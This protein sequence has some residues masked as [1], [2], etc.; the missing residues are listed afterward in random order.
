LDG[1]YWSFFFG[2]S[3]LKTRESEP[4]MGGGNRI[5]LA[6]KPDYLR[7][8]HACI[9]VSTK[10]ECKMVAGPIVMPMVWGAPPTKGTG[11]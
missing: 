8:L 4:K 7:L 1:H 2:W 9:I 11:P 6:S 3:L 5:V 10:G